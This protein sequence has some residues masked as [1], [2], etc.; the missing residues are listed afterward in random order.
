MDHQMR[1]F[2]IPLSIEAVS[3]KIYTEREIKIKTLI[4]LNG[5]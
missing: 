5:D 3:L 2:L 1:D 4:S